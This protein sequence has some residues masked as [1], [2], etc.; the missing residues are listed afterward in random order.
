MSI[1]QSVLSAT[2][3]RFN[4][5]SEQPT[6]AELIGETPEDTYLFFEPR[7]E[8]NDSTSAPLLIPEHQ[9][10]YVWSEN[11]K[12]PLI[13][14][15]MENCPLPLMVFTEHIINGKVVRFVQ[16][17]QQRLMTLQKFM[18]GQFKWNGTKSFSELSAQE[19]RRFLSYRVNCEIIVNPT[20]GQV[21]D[22][23]ERLNCGKP[24]T[25][26]DKFFNRRDSP[27][28][29]FILRELIEHPV[30]SQYFGKYTGLNVSSKTRV[31][32]GDIVGAVVAIIT[33]SVACIRTSFDRIGEFIYEEM[34]EEKKKLVIDVF[35]LY[36]STVR[37]A[38]TDAHITK[39]KK[40]YLKLSN[41]LGIW[42]YW[43]LHDDYFPAER[44]N[45]A[46]INKSCAIWIWFA[47]ECQEEERKKEIFQDLTSGQQRN[48]DVDALRARTRL[49]M[50]R[51]IS[52]GKQ[53]TPIEV[54]EDEDEG[55]DE[56]IESLSDSDTE[57]DDTI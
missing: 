23:F 27:V 17:G 46:I 50:E 25:D 56:I 7:R 10:F 1:N 44:L 9:R 24:L 29:S 18:L 11:R 20:P 26:N 54:G 13:D 51:D 52:T 22:I 41:M 37:K 15:I 33:N 5:H 8:K 53:S 42:L 12:S 36:F 57:I 16:D 6:I 55:E 28:I 2:M 48:I 3:Q 4:R 34:T 21:A 40:C 38:L 31:Q 32:L 19:L 43:R 39:P 49:L 30:L 35:T 47:V 45:P 14:S